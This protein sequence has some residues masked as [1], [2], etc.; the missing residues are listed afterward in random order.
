[1]S[2]TKQIRARK[3]YFTLFLG[4]EFL[5]EFKVSLQIRF[6]EK[7]LSS[8]ALTFEWKRKNI[9]LKNLRIF[10]K[11]SSFKNMTRKF[12]L[13][14]YWFFASLNKCD[15]RKNCPTSCYLCSF[16]KKIITN[17]TR[18]IFLKEILQ[19]IVYLCHWDFVS[20]SFFICISFIKK[21]VNNIF[22]KCLI[23][24]NLMDKTRALKIILLQQF[25]F[26]QILRMWTKN[27]IKI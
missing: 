3:W 12:R 9:F 13:C 7:Y 10:P 27:I 6:F 26:L 11:H 17:L 20:H 25:Y 18:M 15:I 16:E 5:L 2:Q 23:Y 24:Y 4:K 8:K 14:S 21:I 22:L 19:H 1:M